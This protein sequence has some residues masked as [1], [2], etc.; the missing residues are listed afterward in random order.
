MRFGFVIVLSSLLLACQPEKATTL[1]EELPGNTTNIDFQNQLT[2]TRDFNIIEYLY[3]YNGGGVGLA[4]FNNDGKLDVY[5][6]ANQEPNRLYVNEGDWKFRDVT[7]T[8]GTAGLGN[9]KTGVTLADVNGDGWVDI[10]LT[11]V[12][13]YKKFTGQNQLLINNGNLTFT[14][15]TGEA[16]LSFQGLST[17]ASFFDYDRDGD[18]D[19][20]LVNHSVHSPRSYGR[21][22]L[23][24][25]LDSLAGDRLYRNERVP[26]GRDYFT[27][28]SRESGILSSQI[29]YGLAV[30]TSD[31][32]NDGFP[33][34][35]VS[36]DFHENDYLY[37]N[38]HNGTFKQELEKQMPHT[39][40][41]SMG[42]EVADI[43]NDGWLDILS[44]DMLPFD[45]PVIKTSASEDTYEVYRFKLQ[46]GYHPQTARNNLQLNRG[47]DSGRLFFSD[48]AWYAG[49]AATDWSWGALLAD[50]DGDARKD[51]LITN[52]I[53][54]RPN[55]MDFVSFIGSDSAQRLIDDNALPFVSRMPE[56]K[57]PNRIFRNRDGYRFELSNDSWGLG[58][59]TFSNGAAYGDLDNDG[60]LDLVIN[61]INAPAG[62]YRNQTKKRFHRLQLIDPQSP[63][64]RNAIGARVQIKSDS[65]TQFFELHSN[66][67]WCSSSSLQISFVA[68]ASYQIEITWPDGT[69]QKIPGAADLFIQISK[70]GTDAPS[71]RELA[72]SF[73]PIQT[74]IEFIHHENDF[75]A[76]SRESLIPHMLTTQ[77]PPL[78]STDFDGDRLD[79]IYVGGGRGQA[80][81]LYRQVA[82]GKFVEWPQKVF[83]TDTAAEDTDA[84][85]VD[86]DGDG[87]SDLVVVGGGQEKLTRTHGLRARLYLAQGGR[88][89]DASPQLPE[90]FM[91]ASCVK[92]ADFDGDGDIDLFV[93]ASVMPFLYGMA[94][95]SYLWVNDGTGRFTDAPR[96]L[97]ASQFDNVTRVRPGMVTDAAWADVNADGRLD[98][99]LVGEWMGITALIQQP[100]RTFLN[101]SDSYGLAKTRGWWNTI[102][103]ADLD[104]DGDLDFLAGNLGL[105]SRL[106]ASRQKPLS[107]L[108]GDFDAN[109][110]SDHIL[111]YYNGAMRYPF[112][113]RDELVKQLPALK[114]K[115]LRY[116][117][118]RNVELDSLIPPAQ[119]QQSTE[120]VIDQLASMVIW[121]E[122]G[123]LT[124]KPLAPEMQWAPVYAFA[125]DD[126]DGDGDLDV[127]A[128]GNLLATQPAIG[129]YDASY[130]TV[131]V[132]GGNQQFVAQ[133]SRESGF[134][135]KGEVRDIK[136]LQGK[137]G[138][139]IY[140]I[141]RNGK[142]VQA[143]Q[144]NRP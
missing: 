143:Y 115:Y 81:V 2:E 99:V 46:Y 96:W 79:D 33:D 121:N 66:R 106:T 76:F 25:E 85:W 142:S 98:L 57:V 8:S 55:D 111:V 58:S 65:S 118:Y 70:E 129:P 87:D 47:L 71:E 64:N 41:F 52:G 119:K 88:L 56:G 74:G 24:F 6:V 140:L 91:N 30:A 7:E 44:L 4:D 100:D 43:N 138:Q 130:G 28:V 3:F 116:Y 132:N 95:A 29:G 102:H 23:R 11:G 137:D 144:A 136:V 37:I 48:I 105:N 22:S 134:V 10:F 26:S 61:N 45:E 82:N 18:L 84:A 15:R 35:Y 124:P 21:K 108:L 113:S 78:A 32:N 123:K 49:V 114:K 12:G 92:P 60:D 73:K 13:G 51:L 72:C 20:Y 42:N 67:G 128:G 110:S 75:N 133:P 59:P 103:A 50:Y 104:G 107:M 9:W 117:D 112:A 19:L 34:I 38:Q 17:H 63:G 122:S 27:D 89:V 109:G 77:G 131:L 14:D 39:S 40:R 5:L 120:L 101:M 97:G 127:L 31:L 53:V 1:F 139:K 93:G 125:T 94:P 62:I 69:V 16:G 80:G 141:S 126:L 86:V 83:A 135:L 90:I 36:N 54:R 68:S